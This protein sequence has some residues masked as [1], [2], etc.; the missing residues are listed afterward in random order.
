MQKIYL[1]TKTTIKR[2]TAHIYHLPTIR[3]T[4][5][6]NIL[7][8]L[9]I[10]W[11]EMP[12]RRRIIT[13][14]YFQLARVRIWENSPD[15]LSM[16]FTSVK[17]KDNCWKVKNMLWLLER[18]YNGTVRKSKAFPMYSLNNITFITILSTIL[19]PWNR[20]RQRWR[21]AKVQGQGSKVWLDRRS[22]CKCKYMEFL[23]KNKV[24]L[25]RSVSLFVLYF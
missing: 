25:S 15:L 22:L 2:H 14:I 21:T 20:R 10:T 8:P 4:T 16:S 1:I 24:F 19:G 6:P 13:E 12:C 5:I 3:H 11:H 23:L 17:K 7:S 9:D 18:Y